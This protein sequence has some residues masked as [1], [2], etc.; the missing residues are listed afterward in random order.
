MSIDQRSDRI[1]ALDGVRAVAVALVLLFH[2]GWSWMPAGYLGVSVFFTLSGFLITRLLLAEHASTQRID[3]ASFAARRLR[4][5]LPASVLCLAAVVIA[6]GAGAF[7][8]VP[9][10]RRDIIGALTQSFNWVRLA[11]SSS[12]ADLFAGASA[13]TVSPVEHF[14]SLAIE[15]QFY[16]IWPLVAFGLVRY[17]GG[18]RR[19]VAWWI[20]G[21][22]LAFAVGAPLIATGMGPDAAYWS[23][24][25]RLAEILVGATLAAA[26]H[27]GV[28]VPRRASLLAPPALATIVVAS[29]LWP[30]GSGPAYG[31][32]LPVF[33]LASA[34]L[35]TG[36]LVP[37]PVQRLLSRRPL[38]WLGGISYGL[39]LFHWPVYTV[40]RERG[41]VLDRPGPFALALVLTVGF[42]VASSRLVELPIRR[43]HAAPARTALIAFATIVA[44]FA[45][46]S[47]VPAVRGDQRVD[48]R[49]LEDA[50]LRPTASVPELGVIRATAGDASA[51]VDAGQPVVQQHPTP[52]VSRPVRI[53]VVGDSTAES[54]GEGLA[55]WAVAHPA[56]ASVSLVTSQGFGLLLDGT[57]TSWN[58]DPFVQRSM[59]M[60]AD[61]IPAAVRS[62]QPDVVVLMTTIND[63]TDRRWSDEE[64]VISPLDQRFA[65]RLNAAYREGGAAISAL[66]DARLVWVVPPAPT[67]EWESVGMR[68]PARYAVQHTVIRNV[69]AAAGAPLVD[70]EG[71]MTR[72]GVIGD[73]GWRPDGTHLSSTAATTTAE[74]YLGPLLVDLALQG[75]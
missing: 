49:I 57:V 16:L 32:W 30:S 51:S 74:D 22:T 70:L 15:E 31:G 40:L 68:D 7:A 24:P 17:A 52:L 45:A 23:T 18:N 29:M 20:A 27:A 12:Y 9:A 63:I 36:V 1:D 13:S 6:R 46:A 75:A 61:D 21:I 5:L 47:V 28:T 8:A 67:T 60:L 4:R 72:T 26:M 37:G 64:G 14:W 58:G 42:A 19:R 56:T 38:V 69:A 35:I 33:S 71:W 54:L 34:A 25:A 48:R 50:A 44:V 66:S 43:T 59:V 65:D 62:L 2:A 73:A 39:Y 10:L 3:L 53:L 41:L 55:S 11:G